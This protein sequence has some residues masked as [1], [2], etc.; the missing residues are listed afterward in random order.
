MTVL[1]L[2]LA[3]LFSL[4]QGGMGNSLDRP[5]LAQSPEDRGFQEIQPSSP[6][7]GSDRRVALVM[8]NSAYETISPLQNPVNDAQGMTEALTDL[9]FDR[10]ITVYDANLEEMREAVDDFY[11]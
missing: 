6:R 3:S 5:V 4:A 2:T 11:H 9:G 10:V 7:Q 8:G 1:V